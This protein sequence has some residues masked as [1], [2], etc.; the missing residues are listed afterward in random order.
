MQQRRSRGSLGIGQSRCDVSRLYKT[1]P[2]ISR[3]NTWPFS[4]TQLV[5][6]DWL[7]GVDLEVLEIVPK[8]KVF[9][10]WSQGHVR[11]N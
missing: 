11:Q 2:V 1:V 10:K 7:L 8:G 9:A 4:V 3:P 5:L 6:Q